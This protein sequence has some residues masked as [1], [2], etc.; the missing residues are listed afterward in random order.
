MRCAPTS[1]CIV[2]A[3]REVPCAAGE[4]R[5][6]ISS[7]LPTLAREEAGGSDRRVPPVGEPASAPRGAAYCC[8][9][10]VGF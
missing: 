3:R 4:P 6:K 10:P 1:M 2:V 5:R 7:A 8:A 9:S